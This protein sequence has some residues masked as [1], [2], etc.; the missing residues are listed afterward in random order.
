MV[1]VWYPIG[2]QKLAEAAI[3]IAIQKGIGLT[4]S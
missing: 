2:V 3:A 1:F 4:I